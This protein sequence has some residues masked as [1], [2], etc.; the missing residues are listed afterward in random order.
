MLKGSRTSFVHSVL[1]N[2]VSNAIKFSFS[3]EAITI[4]AFLNKNKVIIRV[5]DQGIGMSEEQI[6]KF[7]TTEINVSTLGTDGEVGTGLGL[8]Q[9]KYFTEKMGGSLEV[10]SKE[11]AFHQR[12]FGTKISLEFDSHLN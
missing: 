9:L 8:N 5:I 2:M 10:E 11:K 4:Q 1:S 6:K 7:Y 12:D 3:G